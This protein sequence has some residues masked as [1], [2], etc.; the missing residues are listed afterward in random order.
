M[1]LNAQAYKEKMTEKIQDNSEDDDLEIEIQN[2]NI[3]ASEQN[4]NT[5]EQ[6]DSASQISEDNEQD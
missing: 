1:M 6:E 2:E 5:E 3:E 4:S